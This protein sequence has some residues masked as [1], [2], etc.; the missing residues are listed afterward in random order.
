MCPLLINLDPKSTSIFDIYSRWPCQ[1]L[2]TYLWNATPSLW[3]FYN[4][5][6]I[7]QVV[8]LEEIKG[9]FPSGT[10]FED[11]WPAKGSIEPVASRFVEL[12]LVW[13]SFSRWDFIPPFEN[14]LLPHLFSS[15]AW[16]ERGQLDPEASRAA[17]D[18]DTH[19]GERCLDYAMVVN[20][21]SMLYF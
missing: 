4:N 3:T 18:P 20:W 13:I 2:S 11:Y 6:I 15:Q 9:H 17:Q 14:F 12:A 16:C 7:A 5:R 21:Y 1:H 19:P 8:A 10:T